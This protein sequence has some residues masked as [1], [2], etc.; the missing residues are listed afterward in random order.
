VGVG[1][2]TV[3]GKSATVT[4]LPARPKAH[5]R[6]RVLPVSLAHSLSRAMPAPRPFARWPVASLRSG[7]GSA[8]SAQVLH[9]GSGARAVST[10]RPMN[11]G[12]R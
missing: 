9:F 1:D 12:S 10:I 7:H 8:G 5:A 6:G 4:G 11:L 3:V 2:V